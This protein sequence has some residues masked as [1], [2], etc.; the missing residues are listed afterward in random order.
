MENK[1]F[2]IKTLNELK[3][4]LESDLELRNQF[5]QDP[6]KVLGQFQQSCGQKKVISIALLVLLGVF[7]IMVIFGIVMY[8]SI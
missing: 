7:V 6:V 3:A 2:K 4:V 8:R 1:Q 5:K